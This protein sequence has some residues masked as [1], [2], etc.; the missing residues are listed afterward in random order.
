M[1]RGI[2][3]EGMLIE[4]SDLTYPENVIHYGSKEEIEDGSSEYVEA[5]KQAIAFFDGKYRYTC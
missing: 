3:E 4:Y 2:D 1:Y 5:Y